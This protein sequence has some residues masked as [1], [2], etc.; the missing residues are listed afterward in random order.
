VT[1]VVLILAVA[2]L[3]CLFPP[4]ALAQSPDGSAP[5][6]RY[7]LGSS[8]SVTPAIVIV[9]GRDSNAIRTDTGVPA[10]EVY[11]VPQLESWIGR[12]RF[13][14]NF[15]NAVEFSKQQTQTGVTGDAAPSTSITWPGSTSA[16]PG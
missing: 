1:H 11:V 5:E 15:A 9:A 7:L 8:V 2:A 10:G 4:A 16:A 14:L 13:R 3:G 12:G 6:G